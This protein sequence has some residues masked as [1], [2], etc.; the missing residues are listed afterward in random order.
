[1][2]VFQC[3]L[4]ELYAESLCYVQLV[5]SLLHFSETICIVAYAPALVAFYVDVCKGPRN[6]RHRST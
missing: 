6:A 4:Y 1:M 3:A 2:Q 5:K